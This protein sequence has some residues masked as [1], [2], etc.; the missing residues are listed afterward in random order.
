MFKEIYGIEDVIRLLYLDKL[1]FE[2][3]DGYSGLNL[4]GE[5][6]YTTAWE[7]LMNLAYEYVE[8][9]MTESVMYKFQFPEMYTFYNLCKEHSKQNNIKFK[10][11]PY[12][13][14]AEKHIDDV[15]YSSNAQNFVWNLWTPRK[16][17][18]KR[19]YILMLELGMYFEDY[20]EIIEALFNI[21][22]Y[23]SEQIKKLKEELYESKIRMNIPNTNSDKTEERKTA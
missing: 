18:N 11:N 22:N 8:F 5:Y 2:N 7:T 14:A 23:Y 17:I 6:F 19:T 10:K 3:E 13:K 1:L 9:E 20:L 15:L 21:R 12:V 4:D 16:E